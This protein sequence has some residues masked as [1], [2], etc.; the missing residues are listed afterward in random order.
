MTKYKLWKRCWYCGRKTKGKSYVE[1]PKNKIIKA[2]V[3][4]YCQPKLLK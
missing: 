3:C 1:S 2:P 4:Y